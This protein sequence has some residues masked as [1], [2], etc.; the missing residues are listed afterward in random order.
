VTF[1]RLKPNT[2]APGGTGSDGGQSE[3]IGLAMIVIMAGV[4]MTAVDTTIV[5][6]ALPEI[7]RSL[8]VPLTDVVWVIISFLLVITLL[9]TQVGRLGDMFGR[10]RMY[11]TG[12]AVFVLG[13]LLCALAWNGTS[14]FFPANSSAI[15]KAAP[16]D[17]FGI[18]SGMLRTFAN[19]GMVFS[20]AVAIL[21]ASRSIS[22]NLAFAIF[23][24]ST[25]LHGPLA[26][27]FT[28][29]LHAAFY[30]S[31]GFMVI[32]AVLSALRGSPT[33]K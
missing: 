3:R 16:P 5:V 29:G 2:P 21:V 6:L 20:F 22:R 27:A 24:G 30:E 23:V 19:I 9:A 25:S 28:T 8:H 12:F 17:M 33:R 18:A 15:M 11:E 14:M 13:S 10:V 32:A 1:P 31:V 7:E 26:A 4:L